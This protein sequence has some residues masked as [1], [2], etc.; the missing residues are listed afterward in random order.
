MKNRVKYVILSIVTILL[1]SGCGD[2]GGGGG[3]D[4]PEDVMKKFEIMNGI[5]AVEKNDYS[6]SENGVREG[7]KTVVNNGDGII[8]KSAVYNSYG[9]I[10]DLIITEKDISNSLISE[11]NYYFVYDY[12]AG[13]V[14]IKKD[15]KLK[16]ELTFWN[17]S[18]IKNIKEEKYELLF[19]Y[20][21]SAYDGYAFEFNYLYTQVELSCN[22]K[23]MIKIALIY[24]DEQKKDYK[25]EYADRNRISKETRKDK[26][27]EYKYEG[28]NKVT[29]IEYDNFDGVTAENVYLI[30]TD[31]KGSVKSMLLNSNYVWQKKTLYDDHDKIEQEIFTPAINYLKL[32]YGS[33][34]KQYNYLL[35]E[36]LNITVDYTANIE[37]SERGVYTL[38]PENKIIQYTTG[39]I[40]KKYEYNS[41]GT[42]Y[43]ITG[44]S[45]DVNMLFNTVM[46]DT[47]DLQ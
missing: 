34:F 19:N 7:V 8:E 35:G 32:N 45:T 18:D 1:F 17:G 42:I 24:D 30:E 47:E 3:N 10:V 28:K 33:Y 21:K 23:N 44:S 25:I 43:K 16:Y 27:Y 4:I 9:N 39:N 31:A 20:L 12:S 36:L 37:G 26:K 2:K 29:K 46:I 22:I 11:E 40:T 14:V 5:T 13:T 15:G 6:Y 38:S 41:N